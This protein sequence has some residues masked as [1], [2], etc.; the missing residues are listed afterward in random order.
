MNDPI[1][2]PGK[3]YRDL[4]FGMSRADAEEYVGQPT[5]TVRMIDEPAIFPEDEAAV[6]GVVEYDYASYLPHHKEEISL[7]FLHDRLVEIRLTDTVE[8][9]MLLDVSL[10]G[11]NSRKEVTQRLFEADAVVYGTGASGFFPS[12][13]VV[14]PWPGFWKEYKSGYIVLVDSAFVLKRLD[15]YGYE[16]IQ[17]PLP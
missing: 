12:L 1:F 15:F 13:G 16:V 17:A 4:R 14:V 2:S 6:K 11:K 7:T 3:Y 9:F 10:L 5:K 8:P